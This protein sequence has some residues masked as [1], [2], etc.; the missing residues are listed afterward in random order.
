M[1]KQSTRWGIL[2]T[3]EIAQKWVIPAIHQANNAE[4]VAIA[5]QSGKAKGFA[6]RFG[7]PKHYDSYEALLM[8]PEIEIVYIPLPNSLHAEWVKKAAKS[9]KH[10]LCEKPAAL[11]AEQTREMIQACEENHVLFMEALMY[12]F[13]PQHQRVLSIINSGE[14]GEVKMMRSS[15]SFLLQQREGNFRM[16][17]K[18]GGGSLYDI[19]CYCIHAIRKIMQSEPTSVYAVGNLHPT[20]GVD[21]SA[22]VIMELKK[23]LTTHF[24]CSMDM[25]NLRHTYEVV[26]TKGKIDVPVAFVPPADGKGRVIVTTDAGIKREETIQGFSY[27]N[28]IEHF[29]HCVFSQTEPRYTKED[30]IQNIKVIEACQQSMQTGKPIQL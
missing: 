24:D 13:H 19:G 15:F 27:Q 17:K 10:V 12:Q 25:S 22:T 16:N 23:G 7:I 20:D 8:D 11:T 29:S 30:C 6:D 26:G 1:T 28:G 21:L 9:G 18:L 4:I 3:A 14:I 5:S 2:G